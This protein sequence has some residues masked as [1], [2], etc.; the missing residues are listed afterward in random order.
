MTD[1]GGRAAAATPPLLVYIIGTYP[2]LTTTF[3]DREV[4]LLLREFLDKS[5]R[6]NAGR[7][8][9][10]TLPFHCADTLHKLFDRYP[11]P[12]MAGHNALADPEQFLAVLPP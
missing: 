6:V 5:C 3:I 8:L 9:W 2:I 11:K 12:E 7:T 1:S 10:G 4:E